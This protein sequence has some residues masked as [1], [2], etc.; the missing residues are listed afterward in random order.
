MKIKTLEPSVDFVAGELVIHYVRKAPDVGYINSS[1]SAA[2]FF[3]SLYHA[4]EIEHVESLWIALLNNRNKIIGYRR[5]SLGGMCNT[6]CEPKL[7]FQYVLMANA[8]GFILCHNHP[9]GSLNPSSGDIDINRNLKRA[10]EFMDI[11][12]CDHIIL[13]QE[14]HYSCADEGNF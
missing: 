10:S 11:T 5:L 12:F 13:T 4:N 8:K 6:V 3:R 2:D 1:I 9:S 14:G 7:V